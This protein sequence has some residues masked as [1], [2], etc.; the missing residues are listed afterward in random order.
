MHQFLLSAFADEASENLS[1]Q[2]KAL[3]KNDISYIEIRGVNKKNI[4]DYSIEEVATIKHRLDNNGIKISAIG[5]TI[6]K[7]L[8]TEDF[9][10]VLRLFKHMLEIAKVLDTQYIRIFSFYIPNEDNPDIYRDEVIGRLKK[11]VELAEKEKITLLHENEKDIYGDI[12]ERCVNLFNEIKSD[13]FKAVFDSANFIQC[14]VESY[15][16]A[17]CKL[18][19]YIVYIHVKDALKAEHRVVPAG[20]G[21]GNI[22]SLLEELIKKDYKGFLSLEPHLCAFKGLE[23]LENAPLDIK[24]S[25]N[26]NKLFGIA[27]KALRRILKDI[28]KV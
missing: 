13:Y 9:E 17:Y 1:G 28:N 14:D 23:E 8:I 18:K 27:V 20:Q 15:P 26:P 19:D 4:G 3:K 21:D 2:I 12:P 25:D 7:T 16:N 11:F 22:K 10:P 5:S 6:G 24:S